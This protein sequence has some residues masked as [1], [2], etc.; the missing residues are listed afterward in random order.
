MAV[1]RLSQIWRQYLEAENIKI[2]FLRGNTTNQTGYRTMHICLLL[3]LLFHRLHATRDTYYSGGLCYQT[4]L[5]TPLPNP[6]ATG[7]KVIFVTYPGESVGHKRHLILGC[8]II[9]NVAW[10][11][12]YR[13]NIF[14]LR[15]LS[16]RPV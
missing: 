4:F 8:E 7:F 13:Y 5:V 2:Y 10:C 16:L 9:K 3:I 14:V 15:V 11:C 6:K 12:K 1:V